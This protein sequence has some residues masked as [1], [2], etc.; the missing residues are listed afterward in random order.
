MT[1]DCWMAELDGHPEDLIC[2]QRWFGEDSI[3]AIREKEQFFL[4]ESHFLGCNT[5]DEVFHRAEARLELMAAAGRLESA[6]KALDVKVKST[7]YVDHAGV[8]HHHVFLKG[9]VSVGAAIRCLHSCSPSLPQRALTV[10]ECDPHMDMALRLWGENS[11]SW[12]RL[13]RIMEEIVCSFESGRKRY[14][15]EVLSSNGLIESTDDILR[16]RYS[17]C[18][19]DV[20]GRDSRHAKGRYE[21]SKELQRLGNPTMTHREAV[22]LVGS[23]LSQA[24]RRKWEGRTESSFGD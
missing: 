22:M 8:F 18:E 3:T 9:G 24:I 7:V 20:A 21:M 1:R 23:V 10:A 5:A 6:S 4:A 13:Y 15:S 19:P 16:F 2:L 14:M 12:P 17:A 11:R